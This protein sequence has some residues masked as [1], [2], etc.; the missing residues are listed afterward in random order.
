[1]GGGDG[2]VHRRL[3]PLTLVSSTCRSI[4]EA[5]LSVACSRLKKEALLSHVECGSL[6]AGYFFPRIAAVSTCFSHAITNY[7]KTAVYKL[8][9]MIHEFQILVPTTGIKP[10]R[11][12]AVK[13]CSK[14]F[15][16]GWLC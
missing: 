6:L 5:L 2:A 9:S 7:F 1:M 12:R 13:V 10:L 11:S 16:W 15:L 3:K 4:S 8:N 14:C